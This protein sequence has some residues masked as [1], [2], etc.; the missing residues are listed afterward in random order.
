MFLSLRWKAFIAVLVMLSVLCALLI[1]LNAYYLGTF[2]LQSRQDNFD[3]LRKQLSGILE[4]SYNRH[5]QLIDLLPS[6][7]R[8][9]KQQQM[10]VSDMMDRVWPNLQFTWGLDGAA[11]YTDTGEVVWNNIE[12]ATLG[13]HDQPAQHQWFLECDDFCRQVI[14]APVIFDNYTYKIVLEASVADLL[15]DFTRISGG[16]VGLLVPTPSY[17]AQVAALEPWGQAV[18]LLTRPDQ[19]LPVLDYL[20]RTIPFDATENTIV[21]VEFEGKSFDV[22]ITRALDM[23]QE[24]QDTSITD[25]SR[26]IRFVMTLDTS[27]AALFTHNAT[28][29]YI[30][31]A[32][33][34]AVA[35]AS[36]LLVLIWR[37][38]RR[39]TDQAKVLPLLTG[40]DF[41]LA[42]R[43]L[44]KTRSRTY[45]KDELDIL[46]E[47][48]EKVC[49]Q[50]S[51]M[52]EDIER[53]ST[54]LQNLATYDA[55]T[56]LVNRRALLEYI[57][58][59]LDTRNLI[60]DPFSLLF[61]DLDNFKRINDSMGHNVGDELL[62]V[63]SK[64]L[65]ASVRQNDVIARLG[66]DEFCI[67]IN[68][69]KDDEALDTVA[70]NILCQLRAPI[71][72]LANELIV[73]ASIGVVS[74]PQHGRTT[75]DLLQNADLAMY[76]AKALGRNKFQRFNEEMFNE[77]IESISLE[78][79][80]RMALLRDEFILFYQP[81]MNLQT[82]QISGF[83]ALLRWQHPERGLVF[84]DKFIPIL[85]DT[86][87]IVQVGQWVINEAC[88]QLRDWIDKGYPPIT[89]AVNLSPRQL[90][91]NDLVAQIEEAL[92]R[93]DIDPSWLELE[94]TESLIMKDVQF[95][96]KL[97]STLKA[98]GVMTSI[99][100]F[101]TGYS[102]LS[103]LKDLPLKKL[104]IDR[105]FICAMDS[106]KRNL[107]IVDTIILVAKKL[108]L[109]VVA[110]GVENSEQEN[111]LR[112]HHCN[113]G[114]GYFYS[115]P[116]PADQALE[117][118]NKGNAPTVA[119]L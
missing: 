18:K 85:E 112:E 50:L 21:P 118:L 19:T 100:D 1:Y 48:E 104:K 11:I 66:G 119:L 59:A 93:Y 53:K 17:G 45:F 40:G 111:F 83:E 103:Y 62:K 43:E 96:R 116:V 67:V 60:E 22:V 36:V 89:M 26:G 106:T 24:L 12:H 114:Q 101:G 102:S 81:Q 51:D 8:P 23:Q 42:M 91:Y 98:L 71:K 108:N 46:N 72:L 74:A 99:D 10:S 31:A 78:S 97:L 30:S 6:L 84:P 69:V 90:Q 76:R 113:F 107:N 25:V 68:S 115:R 110:E 61:I 2:S 65:K 94:V 52:R 86:G 34:T 20:S 109:Q 13:S 77:A 32:I 88:R 3:T 41:D 75:E 29:F 87:L 80:L 47:T 37:P 28:T 39:L 35:F 56:N 55:L 14:I 4:Q 64:R 105:S 38:I 7:Q 57:N 73:S 63:V 9:E 27:M 58:E 16:D 33:G 54:R 15:I 44:Y 92:H 49:Q 117:M 79:E 82:G 70:D 5:L 95:T